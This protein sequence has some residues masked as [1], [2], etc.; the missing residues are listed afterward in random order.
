MGVRT[1]QSPTNMENRNNSISVANSYKEIGEFWDDHDLTE[2]D[3]QTKP[4]EFEVNIESEATHCHAN[5]EWE[6]S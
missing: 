2:F 1:H 5:D 4:V 3:D 6:V